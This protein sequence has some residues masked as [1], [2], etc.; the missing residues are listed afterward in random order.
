MR[1]DGAVGGYKQSK[2][3]IKF[4]K[5]DAGDI[6][7][8]KC[9][10]AELNRGKGSAVRIVF[11]LFFCMLSIFCFLPSILPLLSLLSVPWQHTRRSS[12]LTQGRLNQWSNTLAP[13]LVDLQT[14]MT[15]LLPVVYF[16]YVAW[17]NVS[18]K[19]ILV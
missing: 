12:S 3:P 1:C 2:K 14:H 15:F 6:S 10:Q 16:A 9:L 13:V 5:N 18:Q 7:P 8:F 11:N 17:V 19:V 4:K